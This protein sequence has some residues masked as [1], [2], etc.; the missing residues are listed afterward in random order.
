MQTQCIVTGYNNLLINITVRFLH[1]KK[2]E[3]FQL[4]TEQDDSKGDFVPA[5]NVNI[6]GKFYQAGWQTIERKVC[7]GDMQIS[8]LINNR[9]VLF[10]EFDKMFDSKPFYDES[11]EVAAKQINSVSAIKGTVTIEAAP[12]ENMQNTFR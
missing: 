5:N 11:G 4:V 7:S 8:S 6:N 12:V 9:K 2:I 10:I 3:L 1:L